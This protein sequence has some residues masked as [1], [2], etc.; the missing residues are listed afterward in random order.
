MFFFLLRWEHTTDKLD[1]YH[2]FGT[3]MLKII[4]RQKRKAQRLTGTLAASVFSMEMLIW[5]PNGL[6]KLPL[7]RISF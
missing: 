2:H 1:F 6:I 3:H 5:S 4:N 7:N